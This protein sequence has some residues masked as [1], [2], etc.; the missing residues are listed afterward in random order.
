MDASGCTLTDAKLAGCRL[1]DVDLSLANIENASLAG[2]RLA[3]VDLSRAEIRGAN[4]QGLVI[5]G[6]KIDELIDAARA[7]LGTGTQRMG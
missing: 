4:V 7:A 2:A 6:F 1:M 5:N 3:N